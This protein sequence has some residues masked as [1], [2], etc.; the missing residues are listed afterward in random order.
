MEQ[1]AVYGTAVMEQPA[2]YGT[3]P[4]MEQLLWNT[5]GN[6]R[7]SQAQMEI[8]KN[9]I[10]HVIGCAYKYLDITNSFFTNRK[11]PKRNR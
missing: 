10:S 5:A 2:V 1:P 8:G 9:G 6:D 7:V 4:F 3:G 11:S